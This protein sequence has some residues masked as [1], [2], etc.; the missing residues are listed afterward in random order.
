MNIKKKLSLLVSIVM[1]LSL[2]GCGN[3]TSNYQAYVKSLITS[4]YLG[5]TGEY[6]KLTGA[7]EEDAEATY[8]QNV[9]RL[10]DNLSM[11]YGL[12][13][14]GD[15]E[16]APAMVD[17]AKQIY[18]KAKFDVGK[19]YKDNNINYVDVTIYPIDI[20]NQTNPEIVAYVQRFNEAVENGDYNDYTKEEYEYEFAS[21]I[22]GI[23]AGA[24]E[25]IDYSNPE[26]VQV[27]IIT[28]DD[29]YYIGNEDFKNIDKYII[30][31]D[32]TV[33]DVPTD[34]GVSED[35]DSVGTAND[36]SPGDGS[37]E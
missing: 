21:G 9:T 26:T 33:P 6:V 16:L 34:T 19:A 35:T 23:L 36:A 20:I 15:P 18:G 2:T 10:A 37:G 11:Y 31:T 5:V 12:D 30:L 28:T 8:L 7:N 24:V 32:L 17:L 27:R 25:D 14:S 13:I 1:L 3:N 22:I 29:S 4:N